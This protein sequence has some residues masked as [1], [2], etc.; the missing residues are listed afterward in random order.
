MPGARWRE[1]VL[2]DYDV[3]NEESLRVHDRNEMAPGDQ[4]CEP[5]IEVFTCSVPKRKVT[6]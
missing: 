4:Y 3:K 1:K 5:G 6:F 2:R